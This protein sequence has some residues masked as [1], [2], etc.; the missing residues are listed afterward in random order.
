MQPKSPQEMTV[1]CIANYTWWYMHEQPRFIMVMWLA[2]IVFCNVLCGC[3]MCELQLSI[4]NMHLL[5]CIIH[6]TSAKKLILLLKISTV[7]DIY[8]HIRM[9][10]PL[11]QTICNVFL[12]QQLCTNQHSMCEQHL[13]EAHGELHTHIECSINSIMACLLLRTKVKSYIIH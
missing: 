2:N 12:R 13:C 4:T 5:T 10:V 9:K 1:F 11:D 6:K 8:S 7:L 3:K